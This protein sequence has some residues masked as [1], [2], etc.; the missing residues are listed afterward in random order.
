MIEQQM[1]KLKP[2]AGF[3]PFVQASPAGHSR[4]A[5]HFL[6][7]VFPG[8]ACLEN[9]EDACEAFSIVESWPAARSSTSFVGGSRQQRRNQIPELVSDKKASHA[10]HSRKKPK[11][12]AGFVRR[13]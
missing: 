12:Q 2:N 7:Q 10:S 13:S 8:N 9:E 11:S 6:G 5:A 4:A 3:H 1:M